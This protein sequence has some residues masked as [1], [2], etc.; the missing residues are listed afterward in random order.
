MMSEVTQTTVNPPNNLSSV[1]PNGKNRVVAA[2][3]AL[4]LG[5][6]GAHKFYLGKIGLGVVYL[7]FFWTMIPAIVAFVEAILL[8]IMSDGDFNKK[9]GG[10]S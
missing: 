5:G 1:A 6:F 2:L 9:Y 8:L 3:L 4:F 7:V 10:A